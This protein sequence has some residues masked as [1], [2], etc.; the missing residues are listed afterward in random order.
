MSAGVDFPG[1][2]VGAGQEFNAAIAENGGGDGGN[3]GNGIAG[4]PGES[5]GS[6]VLTTPKWKGQ[7]QPTIPLDWYSSTRAVGGQLKERKDG[8][9]KPHND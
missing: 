8:V 5:M 3:A 9:F 7:V 4:P 1:Q 6:S 2:I